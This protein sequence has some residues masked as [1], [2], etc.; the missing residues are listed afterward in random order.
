MQ[1]IRCGAPAGNGL[2]E[3]ITYGGNSYE[4]VMPLI[5][6]KLIGTLSMFADSDGSFTKPYYED[7]PWLA[8][9]LFVRLIERV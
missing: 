8:E 3:I 7:I 5:L 4:K 6:G 1:T 2:Y 9:I